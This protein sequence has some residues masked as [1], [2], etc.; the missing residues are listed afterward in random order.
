MATYATYV[1]EP[2]IFSILLKQCKGIF[3]HW[4]HKTALLDNTHYIT[5]WEALY[6][7]IGKGQVLRKRRRAGRD[8]RED[9]WRA[10]KGDPNNEA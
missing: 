7:F 2:G 4:D 5:L 6:I 10:G 9:A 1:S 3:A 8:K